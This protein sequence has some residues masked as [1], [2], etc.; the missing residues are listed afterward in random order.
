MI[1]QP[2][3]R[4]WNTSFP[5]RI[6]PCYGRLCLHQ[7]LT[8]VDL[9]SGTAQVVKKHS[10]LQP[11]TLR[12]QSG[13]CGGYGVRVSGLSPSLGR[14]SGGGG[15]AAYLLRWRSAGPILW[16]LI[17]VPYPPQPPLRWRSVDGCRGLC[18]Y[19][20]RTYTPH[21]LPSAGAPRTVVGGYASL[22]PCVFCVGAMLLH[23][24]GI[25]PPCSSRG[26]GCSSHGGRGC[27]QPAAP[28]H[29]AQHH[30]YSDSSCSF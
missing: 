2:L 18:F 4:G 8:G 6:L 14:G 10:P 20:L 27:R 30:C 24:H 19:F 3:K 11:S 22:S 13:G 26:G 23:L 28:Y 5:S 25:T 17:C 29:V 9:C 1:R 7:P 21:D 12:Q 16:I 15:H